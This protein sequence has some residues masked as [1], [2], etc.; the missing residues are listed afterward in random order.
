MTRIAVLLIALAVASSAPAATKTAVLDVSGWTCGSC[1][2]ST[3]TALEDLAG[4]ERSETDLETREA[5]VTYDDSKVT[6]QAMLQAIEELGYS[7][8]VKT[9]ADAVPRPG[10]APEGGAAEDRTGMPDPLPEDVSF[11]EVPLECGAAADLGCGSAAKPI[12]RALERD[13]RVASAKINRQGTLLAVAWR[14]PDHA[15]SGV[16][17][18]ASTFEENESE[19]TTLRGSTR[20]RALLEYRAAEWY[21]ATDVDRLSEREAEVIATRLVTRA[22]LGL[23]PDAEAELT[24]ELNRILARHLTSDDPTDRAVVEAEFMGAARNYLDPS[25]IERLKDA[26]A[27]GVMALPGEVK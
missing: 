12:L 19:A 15:R 25:Q 16:S 18:I 3:R 21:G 14:D 5:V 20:E 4:V 9:V 17:F 6:P 11:F 8:R 2:V 10:T 26:G 1:A 23:E 27:Q 7:A 24:R 13:D 22:R